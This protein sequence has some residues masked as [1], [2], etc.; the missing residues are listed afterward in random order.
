VR[1]E[2]SIPVVEAPGLIAVGDRE[3]VVLETYLGQA[4]DD[5]LGTALN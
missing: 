2:T 1:A 4:L 5:L 3:L